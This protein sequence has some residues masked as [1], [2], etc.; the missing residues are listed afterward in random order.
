MN[1]AAAQAHKPGHDGPKTTL[2]SLSGTITDPKF[3]RKRARSRRL[4]FFSSLLFASLW[5]LFSVWVSLPWLADL[6]DLL[7]PVFA[8][9]ILTFMAYVPGFMNAFLLS[10][11]VFRPAP[12]TRSPKQWPGVS[13]LIAAYQEE[14]F[15]GR[16]LDSLSRLTYPGELE[17]IVI[18]DG[19]TDNTHKIASEFKVSAPAGLTRSLRAERMPKNGGKSRALNHGLSVAAHDLIVTID[20]DTLLQP[21]SLDVIVSHLYGAPPNTAAVAGTVLVANS[22]DSMAA[23]AQQ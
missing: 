11:L 6:G 19:S 21:N 22:S 8:L 3:W 17:L 4:V 18:D 23:A 20:A 14:E 2:R 12:L 5:L 1:M 7:H 13:V 16:T 9:I 10:S 15:L